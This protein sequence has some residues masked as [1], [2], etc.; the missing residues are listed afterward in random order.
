[1]FYGVARDAKSIEVFD[2][3]MFYSFHFIENYRILL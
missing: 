3:C 2:P 1:M